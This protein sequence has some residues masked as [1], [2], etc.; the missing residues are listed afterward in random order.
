MKISAYNPSVCCVKAFCTQA[1]RIQAQTWAIY[2]KQRLMRVILSLIV[3]LLCSACGGGGGG[4]N[5]SAAPSTAS[6]TAT[7]SGSNTG[8]NTTST[9]SNTPA[10][11][12]PQITNTSVT[13]ITLLTL[14]T[15]GVVDQFGDAQL[16]INHLVSVANNI[17]ADSG[18]GLQ[19]VVAHAGFVDYPDGLPIT[20]ALDDVTYAQHSSFAQVTQ[21]RDSHKAD[22]VVLLR[23]YANDGRCGYAWIGGFQ[24]EG[25]FSNPAEEDFAYSVVSSNCSDYTLLHE[26]GHNLGLAH[27]RR[28]DPEGG[29][30]VYATGYGV[31]N[32]FVTLMAS[33]NEFNAVRLPKF[34]SPNLDCNGQ[35]CGIAHNL[36]NGT[37]AVQALRITKDQVAAYRE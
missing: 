31:D 19:F 14:Y 4:S 34:S 37:D 8:T 3:C 26:L 13:Q 35:P 24:T 25:D 10:P 36:A 12:A 29:T 32:D 18:V 1:Y 16:R 7:G 22:L 2:Q 11:T 17:A 15:Q 9:P 28:E 21:L 33:P 30:F 23:P 27:S 6:A 20:Q 5:G